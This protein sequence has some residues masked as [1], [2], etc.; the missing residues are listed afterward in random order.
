MHICR[1]MPVL[2]HQI[3][4]LELPEE[5]NGRCIGSLVCD[6]AKGCMSE[7]SGF[8]FRR[9]EEARENLLRSPIHTLNCQWGTGGFFLGSR[10][11]GE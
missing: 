1:V 11:T 9:R 5:F 8:D 4:F 7:E 10:R 3:Q 2:I 6:W